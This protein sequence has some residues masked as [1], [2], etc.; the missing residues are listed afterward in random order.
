V[1]KLALLLLLAA[2][3]QSF[4]QDKPKTPPT[5]K[6]ILLEQLRTTHDKEDWFVPI[7]I[8]VAGLTADQAKWTPGAGDHSVGQLANH[9][10]FWDTEALA[11]FK[12][13]PPPKFDGNNDETFNNFDAKQWDATVKQLDKVLADWEQAVEAADDKKIEENASLIAHVGAH[14]AYHVGQILY[15]RKLQ[16]VWNP[17]N[18]VK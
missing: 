16:G 17:A 7:N 5:L 15:V 6:S 2:P 3:F 18:G 10:L 9:L 13:E 4:A 1:K 12:G 14:N 11:R 8:A